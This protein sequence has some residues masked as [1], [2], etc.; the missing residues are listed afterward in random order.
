MLLRAGVAFVVL[1][2]PF[3]VSYADQPVGSSSRSSE[4]AL[5]K[6]PPGAVPVGKSVVDEVR[7]FPE[8]N[9][10]QQKA[11]TEKIVGVEGVDRVFQIDR[12][13]ADT[14][15]FFDQQFKQSGFK[16]LARVETQSSTAWTVKRPDGTVANAVV[17]NTKPTTFELTEA[18]A[19]EVTLQPQQ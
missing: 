14:V 7:A 11:Q 6:I 9:K 8:M 3:A 17:R 13:F 1:G 16:Q 5:I 4:S 12:P 10:G 2:L 18:A 15:A 19:S